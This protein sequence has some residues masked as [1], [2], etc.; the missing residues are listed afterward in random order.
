MVPAPN[1]AARRMRKGKATA[2]SEAA[3]GEWV[4]MRTLLRG[5]NLGAIHHAE[6]IAGYGTARHAVKDEE[7]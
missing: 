4:L 7:M 3:T 1:T 5:M 6:T 2:G